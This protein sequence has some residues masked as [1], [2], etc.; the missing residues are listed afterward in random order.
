ML[1]FLGLGSAG[2]V[3]YHLLLQ[4]ELILKVFALDE[5]LERLATVI[6]CDR[7]VTIAQLIVLHVS[8]LLQMQV[9]AQFLVLR[10]K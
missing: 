2:R 1:P 3:I 10:R 4:I 7:F 6:R 9:E 5:R 8:N